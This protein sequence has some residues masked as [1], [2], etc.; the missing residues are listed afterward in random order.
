VDQKLS[1][2]V[3]EDDRYYRQA[4]VQ[5][6]RQYG[7]VHQAA[8]PSLAFEILQNNKIDI[9]FID[10]NLTGTEKL[11]GLEIIKVCNASGTLAIVLTGHESGEVIGKAYQA[12]CHHYYAKSDF[13]E[14]IHKYV[15]GTIKG[16]STD[17][18]EAFFANEYITKNSVLKERIRFLIN[19]AGNST[20]SKVLITGPTG[21]GKTL[22]AKHLHERS[23]VKG[24]FVAVNLAEFQ[25]NLIESAL[26]GHKKGAFT[27]ALA[28]A[29]GL[30]EEVNGGTLFLDEIG[31]VP[32]SI[33]RKLLKVL[34]EKTFTP[35][36]GSEKIK[37]QFRLISATCEDLSDKIANNEMRP[38]FY[39]RI[40]GI[41][42]EIPGLKDR[43][44]DILPLIT[45]FS[46]KSARKIAF[47]KEAL[48]ALE[49][50]DWFGNIRELT[51]T[52]NE[53]VSTTV[54]LID[55][56]VLPE[57]IR[58]NQ[59]KLETPQFV[60]DSTFLNQKMRDYIRVHG[61][62]A[63]IVEIEKEAMAQ[64]QQ[65]FGNKLNEIARKLR[66][67]KSVYYRIQEELLGGISHEQQ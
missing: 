55:V 42:L 1:I 56:P 17:L 39:F 49:N 22:I 38:D 36:G 26:F 59:N 31:A 40:K 4:V 41:E 3:I 6:L 14:N 62:P 11:D 46:A 50:Y 8:N 20:Q 65:E 7:L 53:L 25:E 64:A 61:L 54:G 24:P 52:I 44:D 30:L 23:D 33:Q 21:V 32:V 15:G 18:T 16:L 45:F 60:D 37:T 9:A 47:T 13:L 63:L 35:V 5:E 2:L 19:Q 34:E 12:G 51:D 48:K 43:R 58:L 28:D 57:H 27:G 10:L 67:S 66:I 29:K